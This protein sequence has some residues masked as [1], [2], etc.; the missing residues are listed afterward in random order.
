MDK[1][2]F[3]Q[4]DSTVISMSRGTPAVYST[5]GITAKSNLSSS[6]SK[7]PKQLLEE[8]DRANT[9]AWIAWGDSD[10]FPNKLME[11]LGMLGV[12]KAALESNADLHY[13][14]GVEWWTKQYD[15]DGKIINLAHQVD[16][17]VR[18]IRDENLD[19]E[20]ADVVDS[21]E[22]FYIAF[23]QFMWNKPGTRINWVRCLNTPYCRLLR[24]AT[25]GSTIGVRYSAIFP[26]VPR[27]TE[28]EDI[29]FF[30]PE[31]PVGKGTFVLPVFYK[32]WGKFHYPE[33]DFYTVIRN[34]WTKI[35]KSVPALIDATY[36]NFATL[37]Y[38]IK[39]PALFFIQKYKDWADKSEKE[40]IDIFLLEQDI[41]NKFLTGAENAGKAFITIYGVTDDGKEVPGWVIEPI[42]NYLEAAAELPNNTAANFE[43]LFAMNQDPALA[44]L[45]MPGGK[46]LSGS[47]SDKKASRSNK[48]SNM[49]RA[50]QVSLQVAK[51]IAQLNGYYNI[52]AIGANLYPDYTSSDTSQ[53][54]DQNPTGSQTI[55]Q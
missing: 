41:M 14:L 23:V 8:E 1:R 9:R 37:K 51:K 44:G 30:N 45:G 31:D 10:D 48:V 42:K 47:G 54:L 15:A 17:W 28:F 39:I 55:K 18:L 3:K 7:K 52:P 38:H 5:D 49:K 24:G 43:I 53:T 27:D 40:Q 32:T 21:L 46:N 22:Y 34:K 19:A 25:P 33:P 13:G 36:T 50:R 4:G 12:A 29:P 6:D 20:L 16:D 11:E 35:A 26:G 2:V